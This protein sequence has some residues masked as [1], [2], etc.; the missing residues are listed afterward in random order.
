MISAHHTTQALRFGNLKTLAHQLALAGYYSMFAETGISRE[1]HLD[2][3]EECLYKAS[4]EDEFD[5]FLRK[6][7]ALAD[8]V[9]SLTTPGNSQAIEIQLQEVFRRPERLGI[10]YPIPSWLR[11]GFE[12]FL[13]TLEKVG[14]KSRSPEIQRHFGQNSDTLDRIDEALQP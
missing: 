4:R 7:A 8:E 13:D 11:Y 14:R 5:F 10:S 6:P 12:R 3:A 9:V 2:H 1:E